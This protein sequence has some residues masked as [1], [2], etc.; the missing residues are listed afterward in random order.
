MRSRAGEEGGCERPGIADRGRALGEMG[1]WDQ[2]PCS[3]ASGFCNSQGVDSS[4]QGESPC[5]TASMAVG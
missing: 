1:G 5:G 4:S 2:R 3:M